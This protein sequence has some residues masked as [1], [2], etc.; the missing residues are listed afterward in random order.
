MIDGTHA[1]AL[2]LSNKSR[3]LRD[4]M[5]SL[6]P[7]LHH[8]HTEMMDSVWLVPLQFIG[9]AWK[10]KAFTRLAHDMILLDEQGRG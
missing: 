1:P 2:P 8:P 6:A 3:P 10:L 9:G 5:F 7:N 4:V